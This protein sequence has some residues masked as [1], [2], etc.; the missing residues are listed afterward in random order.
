MQKMSQTACPYCKFVGM[1][2]ITRIESTKAYG[3]C[4]GCYV[5]LEYGIEALKWEE[6]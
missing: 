5:E 4:R 2:I 6:D 1:P 3:I